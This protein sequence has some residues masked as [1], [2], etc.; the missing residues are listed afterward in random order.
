MNDI[1]QIMAL[2]KQYQSLSTLPAHILFLSLAVSLTCLPDMAYSAGLKVRPQ[3]APQPAML[4]AANGIDASLQKATI[5]NQQDY[6]ATVK[7]RV[8]YIGPGIMI[9][10]GQYVD[11]RHNPRFSSK[12]KGVTGLHDVPLD[13]MVEVIGKSDNMGNIIATNITLDDHLVNTADIMEAEGTIQELDLIGDS[14]MIGDQLI[15]FDPA[16]AKLA[17]E[18]GVNVRVYLTMDSAGD[19]HATKIAKDTDYLNKEKT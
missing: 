16:N 17:L 4:I 10:I 6:I 13:A 15:Y 19:L 14:F 5:G 18:N 12:M 1:P 8:D 11:I 7:G 2:K 9:V 3:S